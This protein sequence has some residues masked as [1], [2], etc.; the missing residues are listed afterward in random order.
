MLCGEAVFCLRFRTGDQ[1]QRDGF[2]ER[3]LLCDSISV[4]RKDYLV[5]AQ[6]MSRF[7]QRRV[8]ILKQLYGQDSL[9]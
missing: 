3:K 5:E 4:R 8:F 2:R 6:Q 7:G 1:G 9:V